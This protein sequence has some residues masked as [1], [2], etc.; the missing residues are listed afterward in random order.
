MILIVFVQLFFYLST[1]KQIFN[2]STK[3][4]PTLDVN[5]QEV[6]AF[7]HEIDSLKQVEIENKKPK[8]YPFNPS[9]LTDY[10]GYKLGM[11]TEEIDKLLAHRKSGKYINSKE[12]FQ[13][14]TG[15]SDSLLAVI[16]PYFKFPDWVVKRNLKEG[17]NTKNKTINKTNNYTQNNE[18]STLPKEKIDLNKAT[19]EQLQKINGIGEKLA[20]RILKYREV[21]G[22][23]CFDDQLYE[24]WYLDKEVADRAMKH[25]TVKEK[26]KIEKINI[27]TARFK[28]V[29]HLPYIDYKLTKR[30]FD[31]RDE[32]AEIQSMNELKKI[33]S[34]PIEK[35]DRI[36]LYLKAE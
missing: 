29:L 28:E 5:S 8:I 22:G 24:V 18:D 17:S 3:K 12:Q 1:D 34:F 13:E 10:K 30:L 11:T 26:P 31:Y 36:S 25:F 15:V 21:L 2:S 20:G 4:E 14:V 33:D 32:M 16:S 19:A 35:F 6:K 23:Y 9:F 7:Q 27:N